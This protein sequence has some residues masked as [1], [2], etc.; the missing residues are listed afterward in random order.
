VFGATALALFAIAL[1]G[2]ISAVLIRA[3]RLTL[4]ATNKLR[5]FL[6]APALAQLDHVRPALEV[7]LGAIM[8]A[9]ADIGELKGLVSV[10]HA[11]AADLKNHNLVLYECIRILETSLTELRD[12]DNRFREELDVYGNVAVLFDRRISV[13]EAAT[14]AAH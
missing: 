3:L 10:L 14:A 7:S 12:R 1:L 9:Q 8:R 5:M 6:G 4:R 13:L 11:E 2:I